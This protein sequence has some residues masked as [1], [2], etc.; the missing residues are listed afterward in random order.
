MAAMRPPIRNVSRA[1]AGKRECGRIEIVKVQVSRTIVCRFGFRNSQ[2]HK[3]GKRPGQR[4]ND[5]GEG[6][7]EDDVGVDEQCGPV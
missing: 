5:D 7:V 2:A 4:K 1:G 3:V 6:D